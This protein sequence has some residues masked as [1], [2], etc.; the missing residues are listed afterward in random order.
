MN[1]KALKGGS[2]NEPV[3]GFVGEG[4]EGVFFWWGRGGVRW[5]G[6]VGEW[7]RI[8]KECFGFFN[9]WFWVPRPRVGGSV[10]PPRHFK[11]GQVCIEPH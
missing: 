5:D 4:V 7:V 8:S 6:S 1:N 3:C 2:I 10:H 11:R 9:P